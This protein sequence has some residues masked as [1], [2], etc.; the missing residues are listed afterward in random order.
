[1]NKYL[2]FF[3]PQFLQISTGC[4]TYG[5]KKEMLVKNNLTF[6]ELIK[7]KMQDLISYAKEKNPQFPFAA[8]IIETDSGKEI[9]RGINNSSSN[10]T[11]HG[12]IAVI[13]NC[14][15]SY[16]N[17]NLNWPSLTLI[18]T[19]EPCPMCQGAIIWSGI[20]KIVYGTSIKTL[21]KKGWRQI[22][23]TSKEICERSNFNK[24][25]VIGD[26]LNEQTDLLF[27]DRNKNNP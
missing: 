16:G 10:P 4:S 14:V 3:L 7:I 9:C 22:N 13:N 5:V 8:M 12:E 2:L 25:E 21:I 26:V 24:P 23:I 19:A 1:M 15:E 18:T 17:H 27:I 20:G 11:L 6:K